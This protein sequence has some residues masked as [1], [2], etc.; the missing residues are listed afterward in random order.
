LATPERAALVDAVARGTGAAGRSVRRGTLVFATMLIA[1][2]DSL[3][4][5]RRYSGEQLRLLIEAQ[6]ASLAAR[7][8][9]DP[10]AFHCA[11]RQVS[12]A[13]LEA[14]ADFF[15]SPGGRWL[16]AAADRALERALVRAAAGT[17][18]YIVDAFGDAPPAAPLRTAM[19]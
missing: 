12:S 10:R 9:T 8:P 7:H 11:Y 16:R 18:R 14:A 1:G 3:P 19:H 5:N 2:N 15:A 13:E 17:A 6:R 4:Q